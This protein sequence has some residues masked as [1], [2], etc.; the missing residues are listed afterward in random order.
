MHESKRMGYMTPTGDHQFDFGQPRKSNKKKWVVASWGPLL[1]SGFK[2]LPYDVFVFFVFSFR[3][4]P[5]SEHD[6]RV[7]VRWAESVGLVEQ[8]NNGQKDRPERNNYHQDS[9]IKRLYSSDI[10]LD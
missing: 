10:D 9:Q 7:D 1:W 4:F 5:P 6:W 8:T 2:D 3:L